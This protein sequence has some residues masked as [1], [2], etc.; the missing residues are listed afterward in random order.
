MC[1][2]DREYTMRDLLKITRSLNEEKEENEIILAGS[3]KEIETVKKQFE[4]KLKGADMNLEVS[5]KHADT[6]AQEVDLL[7]DDEQF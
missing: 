2:R 5:S 3:G 7:A 1:I 6:P 4:N